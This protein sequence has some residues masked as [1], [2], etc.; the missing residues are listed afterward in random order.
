MLL[1]I[2]SYMHGYA[3]L[4]D[5]RIRMGLAPLPIHEHLTLLT[6]DFDQYASTRMKLVRRDFVSSSYYLITRLLYSYI[7]KMNNEPIDY[8]HP[9]HQIAAMMPQIGEYGPQYACLYVK[10]EAVT[11]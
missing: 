9:I 1:Y 11:T 4:N 2:E 6:V 10:D 8:N 3:R 5:D 7:A